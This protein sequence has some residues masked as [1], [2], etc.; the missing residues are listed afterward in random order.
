[1]AAQQIDHRSQRAGTLHG[2]QLAP[3][4]R[5]H[6][7]GAGRGRGGQHRFHVARAHHAGLVEDDQ[8][9]GVERCCLTQGA[10]VPPF[11]DRLG[12][13]AGRGRQLVGRHPGRG[14]AE[15]LQP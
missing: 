3:I 7:P 15:H 13:D 14:E 4:A 10:V 8:G 2:G 11:S 9:V 6:D 12:G 1:M 5:Q